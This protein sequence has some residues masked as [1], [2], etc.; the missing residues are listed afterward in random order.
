MGKDHA[1]PRF[2]SLHQPRAIQHQGTRRRHHH[3]LNC[4]QL[5]CRYPGHLRPGSLLVSRIAHGLSPKSLILL[6]PQRQQDERR[7]RHLYVDR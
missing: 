1:I 2:L 7:R 3:V 6:N 4:R 5:C